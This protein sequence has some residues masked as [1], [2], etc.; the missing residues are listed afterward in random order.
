M[1]LQLLESSRRLGSGVE[2]HDWR[3]GH[4]DKPTDDIKLQSVLLKSGNLLLSKGPL[5]ATLPVVVLVYSK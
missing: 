4:L 1:P 3:D 5:Q 2:H